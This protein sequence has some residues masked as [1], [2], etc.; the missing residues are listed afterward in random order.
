MTFYS[1]GSSFALSFAP[2]SVR[3]EESSPAPDMQEEFTALGDVMHV[4]GKGSNA[5]KLEVLVGLSSDALRDGLCASSDR[6][7]RKE[8]KQRGG[9]DG[10]LECDVCCVTSTTCVPSALVF[11][12]ASSEATG[13]SVTLCESCFGGLA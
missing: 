5:D 10:S 4:P 1:A 11:Y 9:L 7:C 3:F 2:P 12:S 8:W 6:V 13:R